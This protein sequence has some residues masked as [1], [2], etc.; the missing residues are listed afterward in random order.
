MDGSVDGCVGGWVG[1]LTAQTMRSEN[2]H[3]AFIK[4]PT[5]PIIHAALDPLLRILVYRGRFCCM[6]TANRLHGA[7]DLAG[8]WLH[9]IHL[10][11]GRAL[12]E[13]STR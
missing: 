8:Y 3:K 13:T 5:S 7:R 1:W 10:L 2:N 11:N 4:P 12:P 6:R 9:I